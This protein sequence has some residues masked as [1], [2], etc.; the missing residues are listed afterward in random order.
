MD[1]IAYDGTVDTFGGISYGVPDFMDA[2][3]TNV[4]KLGFD[5]P[6]TNQTGTITY[7]YGALTYELEIEICR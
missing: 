1:E 6:N 2:F 5:T 7:T 3:G 4:T